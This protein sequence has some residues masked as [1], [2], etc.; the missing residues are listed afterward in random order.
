MFR[1]VL[2]ITRCFDFLDLADVNTLKN[3]YDEN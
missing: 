3:Y 2:N 1:C